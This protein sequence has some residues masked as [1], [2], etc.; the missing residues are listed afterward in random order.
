[1]NTIPIIFAIDNNVVMQCGVTI[2]SLL[3]NAKE[4]TFYDIYILCD[5]SRLDVAGRKRLKDAFAE[6]S[7]CRISFVDVGEAFKDVPLQT[8]GHIT[9]ATYYRLL[10]PTLFPQFDK[11]MYADIDLVVQKDLSELFNSAFP[12]G[13]LVAAV[14]DLTID[15]KYYFQSILPY[16]IGKTEKTYFNAGFLVMNLKRMRVED[17]VNAFIK[18]TENGHAENDQDVLN[19]V[20]D[21]RT[22][23]IDNIFNFQPNHFANYLWRRKDAQLS[24][25]QLLSKGTLHYTGPHKPWNSLECVAADAWWHYYRMSP[26]YDDV[27]YFKR[28]F[29]RIESFRNDFKN[30]TN[31]QLLMRA[32]VNIKHKLFGK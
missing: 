7:Q 15:Y 13:E 2:T 29:D 24:F 9:V 21:G 8:N 32:M 3:M 26:F 11:V 17:V 31:K 14:P 1:M 22:Q 28:Q 6:N 12:N 19:V 25:S 4:E 20:C 16:N 30:K 18:Q 10:I 5:Q 27:V 23:W